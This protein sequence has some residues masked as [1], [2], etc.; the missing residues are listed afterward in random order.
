[1]IVKHQKSTSTTYYE[2][3]GELTVHSLRKG[4]HVIT[5][6]CSSNTH[7]FGCHHV[8]ITE[9]QDL[10]LAINKDESIEVYTDHGA[11]VGAYHSL[12]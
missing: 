6:S 5:G 4:D 10:I 8:L 1:M 3:S 2:L 11:L 9:N 12:F 7:T